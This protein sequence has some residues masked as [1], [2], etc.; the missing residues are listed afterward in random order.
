DGPE[1][2]SSWLDGGMD[3]AVVQ[4]TSGSTR[5]PRGV[6]VRH[7]NLEH[8]IPAIVEAFR[9]DE[10]SRGLIWLPPYHDMG[11]VGGLLPPLWGGFRRSAFFPGYGLAEATLIVTGRHWDG[12]VLSGTA[13]A[14]V[15]ELDL[16]D[17]EPARVSC[18]PP[19]RGE[20]LAVVDPNRLEPLPEGAEG[21][22]W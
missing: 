21:E 17:A 5:S 18:G 2:P 7:R 6:I 19:I 22:V 10:R 3:V 13:R 9:V 4:Y 15:D 20:R 14:H 11:L 8:N 16:E 12:T 1:L